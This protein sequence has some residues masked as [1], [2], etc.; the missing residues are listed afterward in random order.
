M[1]GE[2]EVGVKRE[3][4]VGKQR[5]RCGQR[6]ERRTMKVVGRRLSRNSY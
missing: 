6:G 2:E 4:G 1:G 3:G 5:K